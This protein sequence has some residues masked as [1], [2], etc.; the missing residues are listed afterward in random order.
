MPRARWLRLAAVFSY[1]ISAAALL[2]SE[3]ELRFMVHVTLMR[4]VTAFPLA[5]SGGGSVG[6]PT[7]SKGF[8]MLHAGVLLRTVDGRALGRP[9]M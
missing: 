7:A 1:R 8:P 5:E 2:L 4:V 3:P 6:V 9:A